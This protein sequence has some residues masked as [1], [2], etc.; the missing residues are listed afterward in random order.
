MKNNKILTLLYLT[1]FFYSLRVAIPSY[2]N[3]SFL[4][5]ILPENLVGYVYTV[6][7]IFILLFLLLLPKIL[8]KIGAY[9]LALIFLSLGVV[10]ILGLS[11]LHQPI[12]L[13]GM[14]LL[15]LLS[16]TVCYFCFDI[17]LENFSED[18]ST[19]RIRSFFFTALNIA[20]V[21]A[22]TLAALLMKGENGFHKVYLVSSLLTLFALFLIAWS[23]RNFKEPQYSK[24]SIFVAIKETFNNK[25][26]SGIFLAVFL[27]QIFY[28]WM[29][30]YTPIYMN[31]YIGFS[32][33]EMGPIF[34][35][36]LLPFVL[37][38]IPIGR[39]ADKVLGEKELLVFGFLIMSVAT[40]LIAFINVKSLIIWAIILFFTRV[41]ASAVEILTESYFFKNINSSDSGL[42]SVFRM[43]SPLAYVVGPALFSILLMWFNMRYIFIGVGISMLLGI[44]AV[45]RI[46][47]TR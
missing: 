43:A 33:A 16:T 25:N 39:L 20:W 28:S 9:K 15:M 14:F 18:S 44:V 3:S 8:P 4:G 17:F 47:D 37:F 5:H 7:A 46:K 6:G 32:L 31:K 12:V 23:M 35:I 30:I 36:M 26:L 19:G 40:I 10:S 34:T 27:L 13:I 41:G 29:V 45:S 11:L 24:T 2:L 38:Q 42:I 1:S 22:P 21:F